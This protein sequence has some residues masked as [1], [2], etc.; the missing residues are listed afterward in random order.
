MTETSDAV[1]RRRVTPAP[2]IRLEFDPVD[3]LGHPIP[4]RVEPIT[5]VAVVP[6]KYETVL[7]GS[8]RWVV[9]DIAWDYTTLENVHVAT[10][11]VRRNP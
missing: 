5:D 3:A 8:E 11:T 2:L 10:L 7:L 9:A 1:A 6:R 4:G